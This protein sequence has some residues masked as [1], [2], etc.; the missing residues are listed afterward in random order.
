MVVGKVS[1]H[2]RRNKELAIL[3]ELERKYDV[4]FDFEGEMDKKGNVKLKVNINGE[5]LVYVWIPT[6]GFYRLNFTRS[7]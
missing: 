2:S 6:V 7:K 4:K 1:V 3:Y 5:M